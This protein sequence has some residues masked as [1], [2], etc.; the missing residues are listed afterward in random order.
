MATDR[1]VCELK[2]LGVWGS[3]GR[4]PGAMV[5]FHQDFPTTCM[6]VVPAS[7]SLCFS[8]PQSIPAQSLITIV[9]SLWGSETIQA[10]LP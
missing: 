1:A 8:L 6:D 3:F 5:V 9:A 10:R 7:P 4:V 2:E